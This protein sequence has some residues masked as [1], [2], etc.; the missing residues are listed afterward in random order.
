MDNLRLLL[1]V[2]FQDAEYVFGFAVLIILICAFGVLADGDGVFGL[3]P[4]VVRGV[5][6]SVARFRRLV[7]LVGGF[8]LG[9]GSFGLFC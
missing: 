3:D 6:I 9:V 2:K 8:D 1:I 7:T 4:E 5:V